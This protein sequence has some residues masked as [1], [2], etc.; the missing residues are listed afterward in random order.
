MTNNTKKKVNRKFLHR[1]MILLNQRFTLIQ[2]VQDCNL[3][4]D[5][6]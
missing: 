6:L 4:G 1:H 2:P 3:S 5:V